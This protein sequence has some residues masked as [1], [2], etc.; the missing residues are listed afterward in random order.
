MD[1]PLIEEKLESLRRCV[2][3]VETK[4]PERV[5]ALLKDWDLQDILTLNLTRAVQL[6]V[7]IAAHIIASSEL[8][9]P[10]TMAESFDRLEELE[11]LGPDLTQ[12]MKKA[13]GFRNVAIHNYQEINWHIVFAIAHRR[14]DDFEDFANAIVQTLQTRT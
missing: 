9:P 5:E 11:V 4:R 12:R 1:R 3:R 13:V 2:R 14:V 7:D 10:G 6:C 8:R